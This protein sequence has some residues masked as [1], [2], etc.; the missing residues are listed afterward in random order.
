M[1]GTVAN[2]LDLFSGDYQ[3]DNH[4]ENCDTYEIVYL[5]GSVKK[6]DAVLLQKFIDQIP[7]RDNL[8][9]TFSDQNVDYKRSDGLDINDFLNS[10]EKN[11]CCQVNLRFK[12]TITKNIEQG[13]R[14]VYDDEWFFDFM[15]GRPFPYLLSILSQRIHENRLIFE[16]Q[17]KE[18]PTTYSSSICFKT[19]NSV[20][21]F[22]PLDNKT[23]E[24]RL[25][26]SRELCHWYKDNVNITPDD[27]YF[28]QDVEGTLNLRNL[29][30]KTCL[31][32]TWMHV[33]D[34]VEFKTNNVTFNLNGLR[35][36][37]CDIPNDNIIAQPYDAGSIKAMVD[38]FQWCYSEGNFMDKMMIVRNILSVNLRQD[39]LSIPSNTFVS[40]LSNFKIFQK[41]NVDRYLKMRND[42]SDKLIGLQRE[43]NKLADDYLSEYK[44]NI[45][46]FLS[47][48]VPMIVVRAMAKGEMI[49]VFSPSI[50]IVMLA[51]A[52]VSYIYFLYTQ[53]EYKSREKMMKRQFV[54]MKERYREVLSEEERNFIFAD[55]NEQDQES[56]T[57]FLRTRE[58]S[59]SKI[60]KITLIVIVFVTILIF[61]VLL[62][63]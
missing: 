1:N 31:A 53:G 27:L 18:I 30:D 55:S 32:F 13:I 59:I 47:F 57:S 5:M 62:F 12:L 10:V 3:E 15:Q 63:K 14:S 45:V 9:M 34:Y 26:K 44:K 56:Y 41:E 49:D 4:S 11:V 60:W 16:Y 48:V 20:E 2:I 42:L 23:R 43:I 6:P 52:L 36:Y 40:V 54:Q 19:A 24:L 28:K 22:W 58:E 37:S 61:V 25:S 7:S 38:I 21:K 33:A 35:S 29:L 8:F 51:S 50:L 46:A 17:D 39:T